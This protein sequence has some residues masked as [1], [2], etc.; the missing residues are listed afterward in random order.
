[1]VQREDADGDDDGH[2]RRVV[3][4]EHDDL[5]RRR[6][7]REGERVERARR[8][9]PQ[10]VRAGGV[11]EEEE[12][13][14]V[15][16][17]AVPDAV[18]DPGTCV[19]RSRGQLLVVRVSGEE[20]EARKD[21]QWWSILSTQRLHWRQWCARGGLYA[22]TRLHGQLELPSKP[23]RGR[24]THLDRFDRSEDRPSAS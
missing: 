9:H 23:K 17:V 5:E 16:V 3:E 10:V 1:M 7:D 21:E 12:A 24:A 22:A 11:D 6:V 18:V 2:A 20:E 14:E 13:A 15:A 19:R 4:D 8:D